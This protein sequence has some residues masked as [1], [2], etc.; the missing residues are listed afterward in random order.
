MH[1]LPIC[2][3]TNE[4]VPGNIPTSNAGGLKGGNSVDMMHS[5]KLQLDILQGCGMKAFP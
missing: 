2:R 1:A 5:L 3:S 4:E